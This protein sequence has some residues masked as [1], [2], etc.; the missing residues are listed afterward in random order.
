[1]SNV[2]NFGATGDGRTDDT[3]AILH[4]IKDGDGTL[5]FP[6]GDY[7]VTRTIE[8]PLEKVGRTALVG[9]GGVAKLVMKGPGPALRIVGSHTGTADP[10]SFKPTVWKS[11]RMPT[12]LNL[13]IEGG[14]AQADGVELIGT[15][16][17]LLEGVG[18]HGLRHGV[19]LA[20]RNR[21]VLISHCQIYHNTGVGVL[22]DGVNLHQSNIIGNHISY[23]RLGG[24][25]IQRSE[26]RNLQITGNDIEYNNNRSHNIKDEPTAEIYIDTT[27]EGASVNEVTIGSNTIQ[28]TP[29][30]GGANIR[31]IDKPG[32]D[33]PPGLYAISG[34]IIGNQTNNVHLTGC[35]GISL[36][37]NSIYSCVERNLLLEHCR[38]ITVGSNH[39]RRHTPPL[40]TGVRLVDSTDCVLSGCQM[41]DETA[42]GQKSGASLLEMTGCRRITVAGCQMTG[43]VPYGIDVTDCSDVSIT[44]CTMTAPRK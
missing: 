24:I 3:A 16:Q 7:V 9:S 41:L 8:V 43:G 1:M 5:E 13:E 4:A 15:M 23:C 11:Q 38:Q 44:G 31:I 27:A 33:R 2:R 6:R 36:S 25:R 29:S 40:G 34:N 21:N 14:H 19:I 18:L 30:P 39:F 20:K 22:M 10:A 42:E 35:Y 26:V 37:G 32:Q 17:A 28:A 12:L